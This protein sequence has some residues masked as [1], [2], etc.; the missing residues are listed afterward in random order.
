MGRHSGGAGLGCNAPRYKYRGRTAEREEWCGGA[1]RR[2]E[3]KLAQ[4]NVVRC[5]C[6]RGWAFCWPGPPGRGCLSPLGRPSAEPGK[7][8]PAG[9]FRGRGGGAASTG[10][11]LRARC[12]LCRRVASR[13]HLAGNT[14]P[15]PGERKCLRSLQPP[16]ELALCPDEVDSK[17]P[18]PDKAQ[19]QQSC[20]TAL[21]AEACPLS[22]HHLIGFE[23]A[24][25]PRNSPLCHVS[26]SGW[27]QA[28]ERAKARFGRRCSPR[29]SNASL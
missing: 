19:A 23:T 1:Q 2:S 5:E 7:V 13:L 3:R 6:R 4:H 20:A 29:T 11:P 18:V 14:L 22:P 17:V 24:K 10:R 8:R 25:R 16:S 21:P 9:S 15:C 27:Q 26:R 12:G 28:A